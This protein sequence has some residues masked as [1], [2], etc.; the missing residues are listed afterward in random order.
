MQ[1]AA[2]RPGPA[3]TNEGVTCE[4]PGCTNPGGAFT[5]ER[6]GGIYQFCSEACRAKFEGNQM[7]PDEPGAG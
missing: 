7:M 1:H 3:F 2:R 4:A 5:A 6:D